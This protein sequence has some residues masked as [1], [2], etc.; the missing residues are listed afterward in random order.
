MIMKEIQSIIKKLKKF[1]QSL[2][3]IINRGGVVVLNR[4]DAETA[5]M[6]IKQL[7]A[8]VKTYS[9]SC[10]IMLDDIQSNLFVYNPNGT[11]GINPF[12]FGKLDAVLIYLDSN[13]FICDYAKYISTPWNDIN[14]SIKK[15]LEDSANAS[16]RLSYNQIGV[17]GREIFILLAQKVY[18]EEMNDNE[19]GIKISTADTKGMI[20]C[21]IRYRLKGSSHKELRNYADNA[22]KLAEHVTHTKTEDKIC[23][24]ALVTAVIALVAVINIIY[25][26]YDL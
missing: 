18:K 3:Q 24:D 25:I 22:I 5:L 19:D 1:Y 26:N 16:D 10:S 15:L 20:G 11:I 4:F 12:R 17:L 8:K 2:A 21:Y 23:M 7:N 6:L 13:D 9:I 14:L